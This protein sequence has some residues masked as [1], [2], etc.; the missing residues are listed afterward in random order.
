MTAR[1]QQVVCIQDCQAL[2]PDGILNNTMAFKTGEVLT[3]FN[4]RKAR[5][6]VEV[7]G[8]DFFRIVVRHWNVW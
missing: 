1:K 2:I 4:I 5:K 6:F 8:E 3:F 7:N